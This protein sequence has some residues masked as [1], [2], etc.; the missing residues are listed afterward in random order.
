MHDQ[1]KDSTPNPQAAGSGVQRKGLSQSE[2]LATNSHPLPA[3]IPRTGDSPNPMENLPV[4]KQDQKLDLKPLRYKTENMF[5]GII[6][7]FNI[8]VFVGVLA[9][10]AMSEQ[11]AVMT[12]YLAGTVLTL[13]LLDKLSLVLFYWYLHGNS[14]RVSATQYPEVFQAV[15]GACDY[16]NLRRVPTIYIMHGHGMLELF[17]IKR[18]SR[19]GVFVFTSELIDNLLDS[20][21]SRELM[22]IIGRQLGHLKLGHFRFWFFKDFIGRFAILIH[23]AWWRRCHYSADRVGF[24][25]AGSLE[26]SRRALYVLTVGKKLAAATRLAAIEEQESELDDS[27]FAWLSQIIRRYPFMIRRVVELASFREFV[28]ERPYNPAAARELAVLPSDVNRFQIINVSGQAIFGD[29]GIITL[30]Q[31]AP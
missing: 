2:E 16:I 8:A 14:I 25:V 29:R 15:K 17:L 21:D 7:A 30:A 6:V 13:Y 26:A 18:Y 31:P 24:L 28:S 1:L 20:N 5:L 10:I 27:F 9:V 11:P 23:P 22:M 12:V 19:K 3:D 4:L